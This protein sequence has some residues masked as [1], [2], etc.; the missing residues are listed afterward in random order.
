MTRSEIR[1][2]GGSDTA[3]MTDKTTPLLRCPHC[4][5]KPQNLSDEN[6]GYKY[7]CPCK[8][9]MVQAKFSF[10]Q[11]IAADKWNRLVLKTQNKMKDT[12]QIQET[13][14]NMEDDE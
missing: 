10:D 12:N 7:G 14:T 4:N 5:K 1:K 13:E 2:I 11:N 3:A 6:I 8:A 9:V